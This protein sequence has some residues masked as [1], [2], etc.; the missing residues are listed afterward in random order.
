V[1]AFVTLVA[2]ALIVSGVVIVA[3]GRGG[4]M[5]AASRDRPAGQPPLRTA[6]DVAAVRLPLAIIGY[7]PAATSAVLN[8]VAWLLAER[9]AQIARLSAGPG[10]SAT[11]NDDPAGGSAA[12]AQ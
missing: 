11:V 1:L 12:T 7:Q 9:D 4:E 2:A 6:A 5:A 10:S 3:T 8:R